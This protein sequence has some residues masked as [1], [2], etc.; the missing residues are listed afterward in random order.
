MDLWK[1]HV[2]HEI[3]DATGQDDRLLEITRAMAQ[4]ESADLIPEPVSDEL[5]NLIDFVNS[6]D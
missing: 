3:I 4:M 1:E 5:F 2:R 6:K